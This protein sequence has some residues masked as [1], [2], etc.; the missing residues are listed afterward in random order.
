[1]ATVPAV[2]PS[3]FDPDEE[4]EL[5]PPTAAPMTR[6]EMT[7]AFARLLGRSELPMA[8]WRAVGDFEALDETVRSTTQWLTDAILYRRKVAK[9][10]AIPHQMVTLP[11]GRKQARVPAPGTR[12]A[13]DACMA[14]IRG[15]LTPSQIQTAWNTAKRQVLHQTR[16]IGGLRGGQR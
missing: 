2:Q 1:M 8:E 15:G 14:G 3:V 11:D 6:E 5:P 4:I 13:F 12:A 10:P 16:G 9:L 7:E